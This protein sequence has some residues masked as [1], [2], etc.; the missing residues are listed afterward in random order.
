MTMNILQNMEKCIIMT[1]YKIV[2]KLRLLF[3]VPSHE[4]CDMLITICIRFYNSSRTRIYIIRIG[5]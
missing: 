5:F 4:F 3:S 1:F 2:Y